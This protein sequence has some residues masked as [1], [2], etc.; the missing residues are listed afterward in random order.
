MGTG[1]ARENDFSIGLVSV[2]L[3]PLL[4][5]F[6]FRGVKTFSLSQKIEMGTVKNETFGFCFS[7]KMKSLKIRG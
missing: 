2:F 1:F 3:F 5:R 4:L 6:S 7:Q